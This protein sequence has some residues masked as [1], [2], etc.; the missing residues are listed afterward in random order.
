M[1]IKRDISI[2]NRKTFL[3]VLFRKPGFSSRSNQE[4]KI[5]MLTATIQI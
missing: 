1:H 4:L 3:G 2:W 5:C